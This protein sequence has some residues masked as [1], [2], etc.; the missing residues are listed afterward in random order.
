MKASQLFSIAELAY[1]RAICDLFDAEYMS[2]EGRKVNAPRSKKKICPEIDVAANNRDVLG[3]MRDTIAKKE[4]EAR[5][6]S[7]AVYAIRK[8]GKK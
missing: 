7:R 6:E 5:E 8:K 2:I 1:A 3:R 4:E